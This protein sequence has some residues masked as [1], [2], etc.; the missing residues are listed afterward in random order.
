MAPRGLDLLLLGTVLA[1]VGVGIAM[2]YSAS[3]VYAQV[4]LGDGTYYL[5]RHLI[6]ALIG[7][8]A[9]YIGW[10]VDYRIYQRFVY[11]LLGGTLLLLV[12]LLIPG[13]GTRIDGAARW[14]RFAGLSFQ[15]S[16]VAKVTLVFYLAYSLSK[17]RAEIRNFS[18]G[19]LP[20]LFVASL[21]GLLVLRQPDLGTTAILVAV[22]FLLLFVAGAKISYILL[23]LL[24]AAPIVYHQI[25]GTPWR[26][27][28]LI[29]FLDPWAYRHDAGYQVAES[30]MSVG[31]GGLWGLGLGGGKQ[32]LFFLPAAHTDFIFAITGEEL[33]FIGLM[34][35]VLLF[36]VIALRGMRAAFGA[37]D[38]FGTYIAFGI[39]A[40]LTLQALFHM[41][42][43]LGLVPTKGITLPL[44]SSGGTGLI[45]NLFSIGVLLNIAARNPAPLVSPAPARRKRVTNRRKVSRVLVAGAGEASS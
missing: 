12:A 11:P 8:V 19:F 17:K 25:V 5:K 31:S 33:G 35:L 16:E 30:L 32:K 44:F 24:A 10:R 36:A 9:L 18:I 38:L 41:A 15:P 43:V 39:T 29:A 7:M 23:A 34:G 6:Y 4:K 40:T 1:I 2:V 3:A 20:H 22:T 21:F 45:M 42:V 14:F 13:V 26:L 28:R 27:R 37:R